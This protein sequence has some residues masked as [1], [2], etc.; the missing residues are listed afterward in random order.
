MGGTWEL[1]RLIFKPIKEIADAN[2]SPETPWDEKHVIWGQ[3][4]RKT[5]AQIPHLLSCQSSFSFLTLNPRSSAGRKEEE[6]GAELRE[7]LPND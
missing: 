3:S 6:I 2:R 4:E 5:V 1:Y 7:G